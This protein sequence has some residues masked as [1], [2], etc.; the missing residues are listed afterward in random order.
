MKIAVNLFFTSPKSATGT[1]IYIQNILLALSKADIK[2]IYYLFGEEETIVYFK[3]L[4]GHFPN[5]RFH[6]IGIMRDLW[7]NPIRAVKKLVAKVKHDYRTHEKIIALEI[8]RI[9]DKEGIDL[10]FSPAS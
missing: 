7:M 3:S 6:T 4:Y 1:F 8:N 2:N 9:I 10:Y 5:V